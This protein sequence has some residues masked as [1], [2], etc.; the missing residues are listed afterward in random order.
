VAEQDVALLEAGETD[1]TVAVAPS[2]FVVISRLRVNRWTA[3][4]TSRWLA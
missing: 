4:D 2:S 3:V 1:A